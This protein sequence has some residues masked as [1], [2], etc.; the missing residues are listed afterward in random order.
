[1]VE[2]TYTAHTSIP[3]SVLYD[4]IDDDDD[5]FVDDVEYEDLEENNQQAPSVVEDP[6]SQPYPFKG[7]QALNPA[8]LAPSSCSGSCEYSRIPDHDWALVAMSVAEPRLPNAFFDA[9]QTRQPTFFS[10][11]PGSLPAEE[12]PV[13]IVASK[14]RVLHG[15]LQPVASFLG[16]ITRK[17][18][19]EYWTV[20]LSPGSGELEHCFLRLD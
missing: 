5:D 4:Q 2:S 19:A 18:Q 13:L 14:Q 3:D 11:T 12:I 7:L 17:G 16:G 10:S 15:M 6:E 20:V 8:I 1:M 9:S